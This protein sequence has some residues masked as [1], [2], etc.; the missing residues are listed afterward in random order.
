LK[1]RIDYRNINFKINKKLVNKK[2][3][4]SKQVNKLILK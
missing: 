3:I 1:D 4:L 2:K